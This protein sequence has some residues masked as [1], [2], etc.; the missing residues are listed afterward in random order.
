MFYMFHSR[1]LS[2]SLHPRLRL[3]RDGADR[4]L[5]RIARPTSIAVKSRSWW[6]HAFAITNPAHTPPVP[7]H[8]SCGR[9]FAE[10]AEDPV[11]GCGYAT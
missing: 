4:M 10:L 6:P 2:P 1:C 8:P 7:L 11:K 5:E 9:R 3:A